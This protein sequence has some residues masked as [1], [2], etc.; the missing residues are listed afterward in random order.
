MQLSV[1]DTSS[2]SHLTSCSVCV[3]LIRLAHYV[4]YINW[5]IVLCDSW[6][7][8][9]P[10]LA[11]PPG[12]TTAM[13]SIDTRCAS[14]NPSVC[15]SATRFVCRCRK[16]IPEARNKKLGFT[17]QNLSLDLA[18]EVHF[19]HSRCGP[20][21]FSSHRGRYLILYLFRALITQQRCRITRRRQ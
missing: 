12:W 6:T 4:S 13:Y 15:P 7:R 17:I 19:R 2:L 20:A 16:W 5:N 21:I 1:V 10:L 11:G 3:T 18:P 9:W 8:D 14:I